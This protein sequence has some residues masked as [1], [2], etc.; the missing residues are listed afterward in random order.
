MGPRPQEK[1]CKNTMK[2]F[3]CYCFN[4]VLRHLCLWRH[5]SHS[6]CVSVLEEAK[7]DGR[8]VEGLIGPA[9]QFDGF[10]LKS[11]PKFVSTSGQTC[12]G[13][14]GGAS[15]LIFSMLLLMSPNIGGMLAGG[16]LDLLA[17]SF[18][19]LFRR[20]KWLRGVPKLS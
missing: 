8:T 10:L 13:G 2:C 18:F 19:L 20:P 16:L 12:C 11:Q 15:R 9:R 17:T 1:T 14:G 6:L 5:T 7:Y 3:K 4:G